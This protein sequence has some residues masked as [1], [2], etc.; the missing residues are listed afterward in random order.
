[1]ISDH[2]LT[3]EQVACLI[4]LVRFITYV[5][6]SVQDVFIASHFSLEQNTQCYGLVSMTS[7]D[8]RYTKG[9]IAK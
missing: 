4:I 5:I 1:M 9:F 2:K 6:Y 8:I 7:T 3:S